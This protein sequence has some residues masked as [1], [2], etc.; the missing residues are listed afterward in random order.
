[1]TRSIHGSIEV[2]MST[3]RFS[4]DDSLLS[5]GTVVV[6]V[7][8]GEGLPAWLNT[9]NEQ[10]DGRIA[11]ALSAAEF[12]GKC[13]QNVELL[14]VRDDLERLIIVGAGK[15]KDL[16]PYGSERLGGRIVAALMQRKITQAAVLATAPEGAPLAPAAFAARLASGMALRN[17]LFDRYKSA[18][19]QNGEGENGG[20]NG[21]A[22]S[23][24]A[25]D[26]GKGGKKRRVEQL[27]LIVAD[28]DVAEA[29]EKDFALLKALAD[30]VHL[31]RD[32]VNEPGNVL[33]PVTFAKRIAEL[34]EVGLEVEILKRKQLKKLGFNALLAVGQGSRTPPRVAIMRWNG[35]KEGE[36]PLVFVGKGVTFDSGGISIKPSQGMD[37]MKGDMG[38]AAAVVGTMRALAARKVPVNAIG[39]VGLVENMPDG[40]AQRP[41]DIVRAYDGQTIAVLN[42]DAE[43]RLVLADCLAYARDTFDPALMIDLATLTGAILIALGKEYAGLFAN[44]D[45]IAEGLRTAG[46]ETGEKVWRMPLGP[47]YDK[48]IDHDVA[49][50][51]NIGGRNAGAITAAQFLKR[52]VGKVP[53][54]HLDV[55]GTAMAA[56]KTD[57]N[58][59]WGSGWGVR[60]LNAFVEKRL[61]REDA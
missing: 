9:L 2:V 23:N 29:A 15:A 42:T 57:I 12:K 34:E 10:L 4:A 1:M 52:F 35:G 41:G 14:A 61:Q 54:A 25:G 39:I 27:D 6:P 7:T 31:A 5:R 3:Y 30:S 45:D 56:E 37:E 13:G 18:A 43:G 58:D 20:E 8:E 36:K 38:G 60:L 50:M 22:C 53:W 59:S 48:L 40:K 44:D 17:Y 51:K 33:N 32:L 28:A 21:E 26:T 19:Q 49:D 47:A 11:R 24:G 55:A 16:D 46:E